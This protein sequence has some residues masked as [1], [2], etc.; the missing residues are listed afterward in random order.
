VFGYRVHSGAA[1]PQQIGNGS[2]VAYKYRL[3]AS[4]INSFWP[5]GCGTPVCPGDSQRGRAGVKQAATGA[6]VGLAVGDAMGFPTEF[7]DMAQIAAKC[8][9]WRTMPLPI[10]SGRAYV[11][12]DTQMTLALG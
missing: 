11:T 2:P 3:C 5:P 8:G 4:Q 10:S 12:D 7:N 1:R 9:P 6:L